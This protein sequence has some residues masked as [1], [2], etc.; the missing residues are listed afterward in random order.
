MSGNDSG[1]AH[2]AAACGTPAVVLFGASDPV[3]WAPWKAPEAVQIVRGRHRDDIG[4][5]DVL[6]AIDSREGARMKELLRLLRLVSPYMA[7]L[8]TAFLLMAAVGA[9][10]AM[11][12]LLIGPI[13]DRVLNPAA[14]DAA[15]AAVHG[16]GRSASRSTSSTS[17][18]SCIHNVW[19]MVAFGIVM[20]FLIKG[21]CDYAGNYLVNYVG[22]SAVTDLRQK[23]FE[24]VLRQD[25]Q[26]FESNSTGRLMSSIMNDIEK[27]QVATS[28][29]LADWLRQTSPSSVCL[30]GAANGLETG[31][32]EPDACC[33]SC[34]CRPC[35]SAAA[36]AGRRAAPRTTRRS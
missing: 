21:L 22:F 34:W 24:R 8:V 5:E 31:G 33:R 13:F 20:V 2:I 1:P 16:A 23:V 7:P 18:P 9:A 28:H 36:S 32:G 4:V 26:F 17:R 19:T 3:I 6:A 35:A 29:I 12:A 14:A 10:Q 25:A 11:T 15:R 30:R 27:I